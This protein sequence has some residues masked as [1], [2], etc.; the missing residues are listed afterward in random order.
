MIRWRRIWL[1]WIVTRRT[2]RL[3]RISKLLPRIHSVWPSEARDIVMPSYTHLQRAQPICRGPEALA[4]ARCSV[5]DIGPGAS[6]ARRSDGY[7]RWE[8]ASDR[9]HIAA[10]GRGRDGQALGHLTGPPSI[11]SSET[12]SA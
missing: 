9:R 11:A 4:W 12:A 2:N 5:G 8:A 3:T 7:S 6:S 10:H 1:L